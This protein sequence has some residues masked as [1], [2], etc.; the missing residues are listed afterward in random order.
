MKFNKPLIIGLLVFFSAYS[1]LLLYGNTLA[2]PK[3]GGCSNNFLNLLISWDSGCYYSAYFL[4]SPST[5]QIDFEHKKLKRFTDKGGLVQHVKWY[6]SVFYQRFQKRF[7][8]E[9]SEIIF[10]HY[11]YTKSNPRHVVGQIAFFRLLY[12]SQRQALAQEALD[13]YCITYIPKHLSGIVSDIQ[14]YLDHYKLELSMTACNNKVGI[15]T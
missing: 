10:L 15:T 7:E 11:E 9:D 2:D 13:H 3:R 8:L 6:R 4:K 14:E 5:L 1:S 12:S